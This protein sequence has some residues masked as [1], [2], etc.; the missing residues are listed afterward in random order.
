MFPKI[1][2]PHNRS[3]AIS[4]RCPSC[5]GLNFTQQPMAATLRYLDGIR[6]LPAEQY[7]ADVLICKH[8]H[9]LT[10]PHNEWVPHEEE[11]KIMQSEEYKQT[12]Q[13][14]NPAERKLRLLA[15]MYQKSLK[16]A[17]LLA[18]FYYQQNEEQRR[19]YLNQAIEIA[20]TMTSDDIHICK[21]EFK[22]IPHLKYDSQPIMD[23]SGDYC[24]IPYL[25]ILVDLYRQA[26]RFEDSY[27]QIHRCKIMPNYNWEKGHEQYLK[28]ELE[29]LKHKNTA[30]Q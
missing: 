1:K 3:E 17:L 5:H 13:L 14:E 26:G 6:I 29:L 25:F 28:K 15:L 8:C 12:A 18:H 23:A 30:P 21:G 7:A 2:A 27:M 19:Y 16:P 10:G 22:A 11:E 24:P 9:K 20:K 4:V